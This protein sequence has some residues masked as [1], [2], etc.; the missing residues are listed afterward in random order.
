MEETIRILTVTEEGT[1]MALCLRC[2]TLFG[3]YTAVA[4][5]P[6]HGRCHA[7]WERPEEEL[8]NAGGDATAATDPEA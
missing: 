2:G 7:C 6:I 8:D 5:I 4:D 3:P 1:L